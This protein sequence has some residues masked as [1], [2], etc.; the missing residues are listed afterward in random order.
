MASPD[1][2]TASPDALTA[3]PDATMAAPTALTDS[4]DAPTGTQAARTASS[5][6]HGHGPRA[7][8]D[9]ILRNTL[10][11]TVSA[12]EYAIL[13]KYLLSRS[14]LLRR[15]TPSPAAVD[16]ALA[17]PPPGPASAAAGHDYNAQAVRHALRVFAATWL[18]IK[19]FE[20][21]SRR[22]RNRG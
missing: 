5:P 19:G 3:S 22:L 14:R 20:A 13:H 2:L 6:V 10:R 4:P 9:P 21:L 15:S 18:G 11:Y 12:R 1:A 7:P 8:M 16:R 17:P